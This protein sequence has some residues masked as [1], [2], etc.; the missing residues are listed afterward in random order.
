MNDEE[1][2]PHDDDNF[3][4]NQELFSRL[5][6]SA[7]WLIEAGHA[8]YVHSLLSNYCFFFVVVLLV[9]ENRIG[10]EYVKILKR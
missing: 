8:E 1:N 9:V 6:E 7:K 10:R 3:P 5:I 2:E 4:T